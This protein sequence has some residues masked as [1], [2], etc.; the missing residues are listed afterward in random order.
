MILCLAVTTKRKSR[1]DILFGHSKTLGFQKGELG[2]RMY[3]HAQNRVSQTPRR[4]PR[5]RTGRLTLRPIVEHQHD[6]L[7]LSSRPGSEAGIKLFL[8]SDEVGTSFRG[9]N[10]HDEFAG[11]SVKYAH[12]RHLACL[13]WP[14]DKEV[15][16][17]FGK[18][19]G[20]VGMG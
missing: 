10:M 16:A 14:F 8:Q 1:C 15:G 11:Y 18:S 17:S 9:R 3:G 2:P 19:V 13:T 12:Y 4:Q 20:E 5:W 6:R 7:P